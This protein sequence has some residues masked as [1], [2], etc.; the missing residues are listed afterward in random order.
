M[1]LT[2]LQI[3]AIHLKLCHIYN[4][5]IKRESSMSLYA[6]QFLIKSLNSLKPLTLV[7]SLWACISLTSQMEAERS[8]G[9][10]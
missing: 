6:V 1:G 2:D 10:R 4:S 5:M 3:V 8:G 7:S 9:G